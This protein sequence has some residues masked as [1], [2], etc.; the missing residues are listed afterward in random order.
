M[1]VVAMEPLSNSAAEDARASSPASAAAVSL[2]SFSVARV[3]SIRALSNSSSFSFLTKAVQARLANTL[4]CALAAAKLAEDLFVLELETLATDL[5]G[6]DS[7]AEEAVS[8]SFVGGV[9]SIL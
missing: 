5:V 2:F 7:S 9:A 3:A 4:A 6:N 1:I 8:R